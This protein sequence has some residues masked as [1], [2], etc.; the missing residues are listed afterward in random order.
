MAKDKKTFVLSDETVNIQEFWIRTDGIHLEAFHK[1]PV[2]LW[3]HNAQGLFGGGETRLPIGYWEGA[4]VENGCL[5]GEPVFSSDDFSQKIAAK[6]AEGTIRAAS[7]GVKPVRLS[8]DAADWKPGQ[9][10][11]TVMECNLYEVSL[12]D[13]PANANA[14]ALYHG[15]KMVELSALGDTMRAMANEISPININVTM[16]SILLN[17]GLPETA[18]EAEALV[19]LTALRAELA[20]AKAERDALQTKLSALEQ[21]R[22]NAEQAEAV[23]LMADALKEGRIDAA[24]KLAFETLFKSD[25][26]A[27]KMALKGLPARTSLGA[28]ATGG[29][30]TG[31]ATARFE[32]S[33]GELDRAGLLMELKA[34]NPELY[35]AK[36][37]EEFG[38]DP[39]K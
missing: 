34:L 23:T 31:A 37:R 24:G 11:P 6:V 36:F 28:K 18:T 10:L 29:G 14:V 39:A 15:G 32:K 20:D 35:R 27:A 12:V 1:N 38:C 3:N 5:L 16:K 2:M 33:W 17:F 19:K 13:I 26:N 8:R 21:A 30:G 22:V 25:F 7:I 9:T 4:R